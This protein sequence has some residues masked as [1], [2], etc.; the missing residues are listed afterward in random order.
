[1]VCIVL[2]NSLAKTEER[3]GSWSFP[4]RVEAFLSPAAS[5]HKFWNFSRTHAAPGLRAICSIPS[6]KD[7]AAAFWLYSKFVSRLL[8][9]PFIPADRTSRE[10][11][12]GAD[13]RVLD[14]GTFL[15]LIS[16][17]F[18]R[19]IY[20][21]QSDSASPVIL[22]AGSNIGM[23]ILFFKRLYPQCRVVGFEPD[24]RTFEI[25]E[26]NVR[27]NHWQDVEVF[28]QALYSTDGTID[29]Y[30]DASRAG[31][32]RN[33]VLRDRVAEPARR[34]CQIVQAVRLSRFVAG[35]VDLLKM[36]IE[37]SE[38][39]VIQ[40]LSDANKLKFIKQMFI[41]YHHHLKPGEDRLSQVLRLLE[42]NGFGYQ[43][44]CDAEMPFSRDRVQPILIY[45]YRRTGKPT[46]GAPLSGFNRRS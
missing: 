10:R 19:R 41:E 46:H 24:P 32:G 40:E 8:L 12:M 35:E 1:V 6:P 31:S 25:L 23:S 26:G 29:F 15:T 21:F 7:R 42:E 14:Y 27:R 43:V 13:L 11:V 16:E 33:S 44:S 9:L 18:F 17:I 5:L 20:Y 45:A 37:G 2:V 3:A 36:D 28:N 30:S 38:G 22:D 39:A 34:R 4:A